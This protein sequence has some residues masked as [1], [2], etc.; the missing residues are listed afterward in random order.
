[1]TDAHRQRHSDTHAQTLTHTHIHSHTQN[2][3]G[4]LFLGTHAPRQKQALDRLEI[5]NGESLQTVNRV[6]HKRIAHQRII[7]AQHES[8]RQWQSSTRKTE[9]HRKCQ[10]APALAVTRG[11][12]KRK[13]HLEV[14]SQKRFSGITGHHV[15]FTGCVAKF[16]CTGPEYCTRESLPTQRRSDAPQPS[17]G[18][19]RRQPRRCLGQSRDCHYSA[20][21]TPV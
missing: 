19:S 8:T 5:A 10:D 1:M 17:L 15:R 3:T 4:K 18:T 16:G 2:R 9:A 12:P 6:C 7:S 20:K 14:E 11:R 13:Q 21:R